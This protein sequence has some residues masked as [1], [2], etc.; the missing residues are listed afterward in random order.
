[1]SKDCIELEHN[2]FDYAANS[3]GRLLKAATDEL[4]LRTKIDWKNKEERK[5]E[6]QAA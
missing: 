2:L 6:R 4:Q 5:N 1:M 3:N